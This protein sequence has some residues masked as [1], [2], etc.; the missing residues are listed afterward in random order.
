MLRRVRQLLRLQ[1]SA[2]IVPSSL[3]LVKLM[4]EAV[5]SSETSVPTRATRRNVPEDGIL[6]TFCGFLCAIC[7][8]TKQF[9][10]LRPKSDAFLRFLVP[11][12]WDILEQR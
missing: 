12:C 11:S 6:N 1:I 2:N 5:C 9:T 8:S 7:V 3:I 10:H 4:M